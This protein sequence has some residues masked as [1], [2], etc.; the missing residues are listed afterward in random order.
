MYVNESDVGLL[1]LSTSP[2]YTESIMKSYRFHIAEM[3]CASCTVL[4]ELELSKHPEVSNVHTELTTKTVSVTGDFGAKTPEAIARELS[5]RMQTY[6]Y[7]VTPLHTPERDTI[8]IPQ[9]FPI[10][11]FPIAAGVVGLFLVIQNLGLADMLGTRTAPSL[12][13]A[14]LI[15]FIASL[16]S[17][18]AVV[19]G[20]AL[21]LTA[22]YAA[23]GRRILPQLSF[24]VGRLVSFFLLG[25]ALGA[26]GTIITLR[27][28]TTLLIHLSIA[29]IMLALGLHLLN[30][31]SSSL[32]TLPAFVTAPMRYILRAQ[33]VVTPFFLGALTFFLPCGFTQSAQFYTL[34]LGSFQAGALFMSMF[35]LGTLPVLA[36]ISFLPL[37][38]RSIENSR[39]F[40]SVAGLLVAFF[41]LYTLFA[42]LTSLV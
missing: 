8:E 18:G 20:L 5:E 15:G 13:T 4:T 11:A 22:Q 35:A 7:T 6:G 36:V 29:F 28:Y 38:F 34:T 10:I 31:T 42:I 19:G 14:L 30:I 3:H 23:T 26:L 2:V 39:V 1:L 32:L 25:G 12:T 27:F 21:S 40:N 24:H 16:S 41:A 17:C 33:G 37:A 9:P